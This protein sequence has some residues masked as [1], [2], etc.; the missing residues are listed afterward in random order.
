MLPTASGHFYLE[1]KIYIDNYLALYLSHLPYGL[2]VQQV[3][4]DTNIKMSFLDKHSLINFIDY[5]TLLT[6][7]GTMAT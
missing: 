6:G 3:F 7:A 2:N 1:I 4:N 5:Q